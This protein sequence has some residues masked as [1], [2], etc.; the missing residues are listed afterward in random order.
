MCYL[1]KTI[2]FFHLKIKLEFEGI[3]LNKSTFYRFLLLLFIMVA[4]HIVFQISLKFLYKISL[5][6]QNK[7]VI[8]ICKMNM[9]V[10]C[11]RIRI[12]NV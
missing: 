4:L 11:T 9:A 7:Y 3:F 10:Q 5:T 1:I 8:S 12:L 6:L 2:V